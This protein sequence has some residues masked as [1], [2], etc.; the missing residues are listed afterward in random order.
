MRAPA[1]ASGG[2]SG[3]STAPSA[4]SNFSSSGHTTSSVD[5]DWSAASDTGGSGLDHYAVYVN[6]SQ[7]G[8]VSA[9]TTSTTVSGLSGG[10]TYDF[11]VTAVDGAGNESSA[12]NTV[13][14]TTNSSG[15]GD[16]NQSVSRIDGSDSDSTVD[17]LSFT[18]VSNVGSNWVDVHY[19][20]NG[21]S[22]YNYRMNKSG[23]T[24]TLE[25]TPDY[26]VGDFSSGDAI[27]YYFTYENGG[28]GNDSQHFSL[29][30]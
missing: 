12:S 25:T 28:T 20:V 24:H 2:G 17:E 14:V 16:F 21:G 1:G 6:G 7:N 30:Y 5:L 23:D 8:T 13:S 22:Q 29:T 11:S 18:F 26:V 10:T 9:G 27:D 3:D 15:S 19:T 4:P